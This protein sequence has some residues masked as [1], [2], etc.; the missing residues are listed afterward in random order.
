VT[1]HKPH[2]GPFRFI[3][4]CSER[5][6]LV[7]AG[8]RT[9]GSRRVAYSVEIQRPDRPDSIIEYTVMP[10]IQYRK[11]I[12]RTWRLET[13]DSLYVREARRLNAR[14]RETLAREAER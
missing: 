13:A 9:I 14:V 11:K 12:V 4:A 8:E 6:Y 1:E 2:N 10:A 5:G 3:T 7:G